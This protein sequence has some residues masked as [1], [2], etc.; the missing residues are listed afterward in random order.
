MFTLGIE[1]ATTACSVA[2]LSSDTLVSE[3]RI[4]RKNIHAEKLFGCI[5]KVFAL[6]DVAIGDVKGIAVSIGPGSFTGLRIGLSAAKGLAYST[7]AKI[8]AVPT[9]RAIAEHVSYKC[10]NICVLIQSRKDEFYMAQY[11]HEAGDISEVLAPSIISAD[12]MLNKIPDGSVIVG[13]ALLKLDE[14]FLAKLQEKYLVSNSSINLPN[15]YAVARLGFKKFQEGLYDD[16]DSLEPF[17]LQDFIAGKPK[18][19]NVQSS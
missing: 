19:R 10:A 8:I 15:A 9:L 13:P 12:D 18:N 6:G 14:V 2:L 4:V 7:G 17:Y 11:S 16:P 1:T 3:I 5:Q